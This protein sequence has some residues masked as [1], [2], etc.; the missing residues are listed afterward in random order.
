MIIAVL[1]TNV[2]V[3]ALCLP[4]SLPAQLLRLWL[5]RQ[6]ELVLSGMILAELEDVLRRP[7]ISRRYG[8]TEESIQTFT[9][10]LVELARMVPIVRELEVI[11]SDPKDNHVVTC[12]VEGGASFI[13]SGDRHLTGLG[14]YEA[15][16]IVTP[17]QF[18]M[19]L[20]ST[21]PE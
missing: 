14:Q 12:A 20:Q 1:D 18:L 8:I 11:P 17:A 6:F 2:L 10:V 7:K 4:S 19:I 21:A 3:S 9:R 16:R 5:A 13:V 15:I